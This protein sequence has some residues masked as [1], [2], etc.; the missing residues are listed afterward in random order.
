[1]RK[2]LCFLSD[3]P[4]LSSGFLSGSYSGGLV[5]YYKTDLAAIVGWSHLFDL[6]SY[7]YLSYLISCS[8]TKVILV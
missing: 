3:G 7:S 2:N 1:M 6:F 4:Q 8:V 5:C